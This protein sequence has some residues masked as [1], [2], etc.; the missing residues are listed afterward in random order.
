MITV[1]FEKERKIFATQL[2]RIMELRGVKAKELAD[3]LG[4]GVST[5]YFWSRHQGF[6]R[7]ELLIALSRF[8]KVPIDAF[9]DEGWKD[10]TNR[11]RSAKRAPGR[12]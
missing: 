3:E 11:R 2:F 7:V 12:S 1:D 10:E 5:V 6:P 9:F 8:L 4:V